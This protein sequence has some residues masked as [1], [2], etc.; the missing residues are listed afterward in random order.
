MQPRR[1]AHPRVPRRGG[2]G[3]DGKGMRF[4]LLENQKALPDDTSTVL[5]RAKDAVQARALAASA[6]GKYDSGS[7]AFLQ[8]RDSTV[9]IV[10][11]LGRPAVIVTVSVFE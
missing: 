4:Y 10:H 5:V 7:Y 6:C 3:R 1:R 9:R 8:P 11:Q 2:Q